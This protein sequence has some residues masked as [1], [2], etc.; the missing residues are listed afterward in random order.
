M[1]K[2]AKEVTEMLSTIR[3]RRLVAAAFVIGVLAAAMPALSLAANVGGG[4]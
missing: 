2:R 3:A 4:P 1:S